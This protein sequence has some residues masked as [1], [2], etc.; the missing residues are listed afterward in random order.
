MLDKA[1][2]KITTRFE[3]NPFKKKN[4]FKKLKLHF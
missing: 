2:K 3:D 1:E 4:K